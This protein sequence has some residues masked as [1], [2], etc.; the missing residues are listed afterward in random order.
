[1]PSIVASIR[2][3]LAKFA[4]VRIRDPALFDDF[5]HFETWVNQQQWGQEKQNKHR[6][7]KKPGGVELPELEVNRADHL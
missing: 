6:L 2:A 5:D 3:D 4:S 1:M 7:G